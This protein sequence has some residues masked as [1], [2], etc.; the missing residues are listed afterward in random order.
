MI[1]R[2]L[3]IFAVAVTLFYAACT[4]SD[5]FL[6]DEDDSIFID[7]SAEMAFSFDS[8]SQRSKADTISPNDTLIFI[9]NIYPSKSIKIRRYLWTLDGIPLS[10]D[11]SFRSTIDKPGLHKVAFILETFLGDTL[12]DTLSLWISNPPI[13]KDSAFIPAKGS[14]GIPTTGGISFAWEAY[15][16]DSMAT[17]FY[18]FIID[19]LVDT[20]LS[21]P[22]FTYWKKLEPLTHYRWHV[23]AINEFGFIS[24]STI[25]GNFY[26]S[27]GPNEGGITGFIA[28][29]AKDNSPNTFV[30]STRLSILDSAGNECYSRDINGSSQTVQPFVVSPL[31]AGEYKVAFNISKYPDFFKDTLDIVIFPNEVVELD[32]IILRDTIP[33]RVSYIANDSA[34]NID[35][36]EYAD[37]LKFLITDFGTPL[38][39][40]TVYAYL[41]SE[42]L[43]EKVGSGDTFTVALPSTAKSWT[44]QQLDL[45]AIDASKNKTIHSYFIKPA[46]SWIK[47][48]ASFTQQGYG[49]INLYIID[50]NPY[51]FEVNSCKFIVNNTVFD[52][53]NYPGLLCSY[54]LYTSELTEGVNTIK[55][56]VEYTNGINYW[57]EWY[58][59]YTEAE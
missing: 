47:T 49:K 9:A 43:V 59:T 57:K 23:Q 24:E 52:G 34:S 11:F 39:Q 5:D 51:N 7:I 35:T 31:N 54:I 1:F 26:T 55:S 18:H 15:D 25:D 12:S 19:G 56:I 32:T 16:P 20:I 29:S 44:M 14:Q 38:T 58:I 27:G 40:K 45:I 6:Y 3:A 30:I 50:E 42:L 21:E 2:I 28:V 48:N 10:Y 36:L 33:P 46:E 22:N 8:M 41:E 53:V 13:L 4:N 17:L 37:T